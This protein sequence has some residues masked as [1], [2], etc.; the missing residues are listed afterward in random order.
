MD[1]LPGQ[2]GMIGIPG[3]KGDIGPMGPVGMKGEMGPQV[4][5]SNH[6]HQPQVVDGCVMSLF[7]SLQKTLFRFAYLPYQQNL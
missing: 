3:V 7:T 4:K 2:R 5:F 1:G 6:L